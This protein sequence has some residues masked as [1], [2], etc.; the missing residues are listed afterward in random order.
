MARTR[1]L[2]AHRKVLDAA[3]ELVADAGVEATSMDAIARKSGVSKATIYK[4]WADK[5][6]L[7]L[8]MMAVAA[9]L[10]TR[11][12]FDSRDG[13]GTTPKGVAAPDRN[14]HTEWRTAGDAGCRP[15]ARSA[16]RSSHLLARFS[17]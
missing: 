16:A 1:S 9:G 7:L 13:H 14:R 5:D 12:K 4:H 8:E 11:P 2:S 15:V 17:E 10:H 3:L 6:A